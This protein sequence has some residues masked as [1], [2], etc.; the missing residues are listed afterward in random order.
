MSKA[1]TM[2]D[3]M[4]QLIRDEEK[5]KT[6]KIA[7][8]YEIEGRTASYP[9]DLY[10]EFEGGNGI[11]YKVIIQMKN[12]ETVVNRNQLFHFANVL[13]DISGQVMGVIFT[14]P[15][16]EKLVKD[17]ARD[18]GI[19][20]YEMPDMNDKPLWQPIIQQIHI[21]VDKE[22]AKIEK[23]K[24]GLQDEPISYHGEPKSLF[25]YNDSDL[26][27]DSLEGIFN[28]HIKKQRAKE[29]FDE[30]MIEH[31]FNENTYLQTGHPIITKVKVNGVS[32]SLAFQNIA[33]VEK[34]EIIQDIFNAALRAKLN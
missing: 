28:D 30:V 2:I 5:V 12:M 11:V 15:V 25:L 18:V 24:H 26:C 4:I 16:Y 13:Q 7:R 27:I 3:E 29:A 22:W 32:F 14:Q 20:L 10:W 34:G 23:A 21:D 31:K 19:V 8:D 33:K 1:E 9:V 17:V 6:I